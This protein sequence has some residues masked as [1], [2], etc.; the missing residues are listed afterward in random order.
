MRIPAPAVLILLSLSPALA[1]TFPGW[2][3]RAVHQLSNR[4]RVA[5]SA[6]LAACANGQ[7]PDAGCYAATAPL[8]WHYDLNQ[9]AR[10]HS[11][12]MG[13]FPFFA[14]DTPCALFSDIDTRYPGSSDGSFASSCSSS[15]TTFAFARVS[16]F[17]AGY[18]GE[19]AAAG[20]FSPHS[21][22]YAWLHEPTSSGACGFTIQNGHRYNILAN[23]GPAMGVGHAYVPGSPYGNYWTQDFGGSGPIPKIPS[24]SHWTAG[25]RVRDPSGGDTNVEFWA[26]WYDPSGGAPVSAS[27]V[28]DNVPTTMTRARG[29]AANGAWFAQVNAV[30]SGCHAYFFSFVDSSLNTVRHPA[31]GSLGFGAGCSDFQSGAAPGAPAG[32]NA[33]ASTSTQVQVT[34]N[35]A[36][37]ATSY[38]IYRRDPGGAVSLRGT[39]S[40]LSFNDAASANSSYLYWVRAVNAVGSSGDSAADLATTVMFTGD[41]LPAGVLITAARLAELRTAVAAVRAQAGLGAAT[42]TNAAAAGVSVKAVHITELRAYLDAAMT[43]MGRATGGWTDASLTGVGI[44]TTH[45]QEIRNRVK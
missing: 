32:V 39:S 40:T 36:A 29:T 43:A 1:Q 41:P 23:G 22:F 13:R 42:W 19:N 33:V 15:G 17:G 20:Q 44:K 26:N 21:V 16:M 11:A 12:S 2:E 24:G 4:A 37:T 3:E 7:C 6:E 45:W 25:D 8:A 18:S 38:Q 31:T 35:A 34:W 28:L 10:F 27:V 5:P 30:S 9:A 14:H